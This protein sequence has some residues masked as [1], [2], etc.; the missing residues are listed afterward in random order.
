MVKTPTANIKLFA[1]AKQVDCSQIN[2]IVLTLRW[3]ESSGCPL[4]VG[5]IVV[6]E[7]IGQTGSP[8]TKYVQCDITCMQITTQIFAINIR[9]RGA[10]ILF[11][12]YLYNATV[13][14]WGQTELGLSSAA[15][16][17]QSLFIHSDFQE[18][19]FFVQFSQARNRP[20][21]AF[22]FICTVVVGVFDEENK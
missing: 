12:I 4:K 5:L 10:P 16:L 22:Q 21:F 6:I 20:N 17:I 14:N 1:N 15:Q 2:E 7:N 19:H 11:C 13:R 9:I 3:N 8:L 18:I